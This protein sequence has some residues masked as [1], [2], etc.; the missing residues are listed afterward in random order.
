MA[1]LVLI[2]MGLTALIG[3][4]MGVKN[5]SVLA[6]RVTAVEAAL[7]ASGALADFAGIVAS[8]SKSIG[9]LTEA[10][11]DNTITPEELQG[12]IDE[13]KEAEKHALSIK[14][15]LGM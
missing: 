5:S 12:I 1:D 4:I 15:K 3:L 10:Q 9:M 8:M 11:K 14:A 7:K 6:G 2:A 13:M